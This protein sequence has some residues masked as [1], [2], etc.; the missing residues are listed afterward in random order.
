MKNNN[1]CLVFL[2]IIFL[3]IGYNITICS[4]T[5]NFLKI[6]VGARASGMAEAFSAVSDDVSGIYYNP[7]G[8][9]QCNFQELTFGYNRFIEDIKYYFTGYNLPVN[10]SKKKK[11]EFNVGV[12]I[13]YLGMNEIK[14]YNVS[15]L[16]EGT[17]TI[18]DLALTLNYAQRIV[19]YPDIIDTTED[20]PGLYIGGDVKFIDKKLADINSTGVTLDIG[21][22]FV[23]KFAVVDGRLRFGVNLQNL[24]GGLKFDKETSPFPFNTRVGIAFKKE[25][26]GNPVTVA[27]DINFNPSF[28][29]LG[30]EYSLLDVISL[31]CGYKFS[32]QAQV[33][34]GIRI[35]FG[36]GVTNFRFDY[37][38]APTETFGDTHKVSITMKFLPIA[39]SELKFVIWSIDKHYKKAMVL[40]D[41]EKYIDA[42]KELN[43]ILKLD[44]T[45]PQA[46]QQLT[47]IEDMFKK[48]QEAREKEKLEKQIKEHFSKAKGLFDMGDL[49]KAKES[50]EIILQLDPNHEET[51]IYLQRIENIQKETL[52]QRVVV[53]LSEGINFYEKGDYEKAIQRFEGVLEIEP[54]NQKAKEYLQLVKSKREEKIKKE[55]E[56]Q[57]AKE[58]EKNYNDAVL[59]MNKGK[60]KEAMDLLKKVLS[61]SPG[62]KDTQ[63]LLSQ[64]EQSYK[65][66]VAKNREESAKLYTEGLKAYTSG[67]LKKAYELW[68]KAAELDPQNEKA[69]KGVERLQKEIKK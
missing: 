31:R 11:T 40:I 39:V 10:F 32:S 16:P 25:V 50:F 23:P 15:G 26:I 43:Y 19:K 55:Q 30:V 47:K 53:Y 35:G 9:A 63:K 58:V 42:Y 54:Q 57:Q 52:R 48:V 56:L 66:Q 1:F 27:S 68:K 60:Y 22:L 7:A 61:L 14:T 51:K 4:T 29:S 44:P 3:F 65:Q 20:K 37:S 18:S 64:A 28:V 13:F 21:M 45:H 69:V 2:I 62:Y 67:D 38:Y 34:K 36:I 41:R 6:G 12:G 17:T 46:K 33:D 8:I 5:A 59:Y 49:L 24:F